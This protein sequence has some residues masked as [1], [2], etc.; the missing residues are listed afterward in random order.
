MLED[1]LPFYDQLA[2]MMTLPWKEFD[3]QYPEFVKKAKAAMPLATVLPDWP[4]SSAAERR[5]QTQMAL[6]R[7]RLPSSRAGRTSSRTSRIRSATGRSSTAP[8]TKGLS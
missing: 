3:A 6:F 7:P 2:K 8:W 4:S 1:L 5:H